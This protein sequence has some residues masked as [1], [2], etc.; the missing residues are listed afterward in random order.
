[1]GIAETKKSTREEFALKALQRSGTLKTADV[2]LQLGISESTVRRLFADLE[3]RGEATRVH[4]G[5][6]PAKR[7]QEEYSFENL[8]FHQSEKKTRIGRFGSNLVNNGDNIF[9]DTGTTIQQM[10]LHLVERHK[11]GELQE[12]QVYT[13]SLRNL[14]ILMDYFE[15]NLVGGSFRSRRQDFCGY[16]SEI[17]LESISFDKCFLSADGVSLDENGITASDIFTA[18]IDQIVTRR[19][20]A[21]YLL[22]DSTKFAKRSFKKYADLEDLEMLITDDTLDPAVADEIIARGVNLKMV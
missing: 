19:A 18:K 17:V 7:R 3:R 14:N 5:V 13:N 22:A 1:M 9:L 4:G 6:K 11:A 12:L 15:V 21:S 8:Q 10:A 16:L 20:S 2:A